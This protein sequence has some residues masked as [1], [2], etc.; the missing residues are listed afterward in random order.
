MKLP[1][2]GA[3]HDEREIEAVVAVL[4]SSTLDIGENVFEFERRTASL[5]SKQHGIMVNSGSSALRIAVDLLQLERGDEI[6]TSPLTFSTDIATMVQSGLVPVFVDITPDT[7]Q[8]DHTKIEAMIGPRTKA[9]LTPNL[10]GN[11]PD[12][13]AIRAIADTHGLK[14]VEDSCDVLDSWQRGERTG[15][16]ADIAVTSFARSHAMT[17]G[18]AGG[19]V[20]VDDP[21]LFDLG[22][23]L[24][25]WGRR[26]EPYLY[27]S[28]KG[29]QDRFGYLADGTP[30]DMIFTFDSIGYNFEPTEISA[31]YGLVQLD[32]LAGFNQQRRDNWR[33]LDDFLATRDGVTRGR[34]TPETDTTWMRFCFTIDDDL[35][36]D[37]SEVQERLEERGV[38]TRMVWTGN[39]LRQPGFAGIEH[40]A[41]EGG[42]PNCDH[43]MD[44]ALSLPV[45]HGLNADHMGYMCEQLDAVLCS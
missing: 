3:V 9:I 19:L 24:R 39:I 5:L 43:I 20:G 34:T 25:R 22:L 17:A 13:D 14:V 15:A 4:R 1:V 28:R 10:C 35:G 26:S 2:S 38:A 40:R 37:R 7:Y 32:K 45:H 29:L 12:W 36:I 18:G 42:L 33:R 8:I 23:E 16:R 41:P 44:N 30:Y 11:C 27:G 6:I 31:A 21:E